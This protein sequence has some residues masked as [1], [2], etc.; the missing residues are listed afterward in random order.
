MSSCFSIRIQHF[1]LI[2]KLQ[3]NIFST[4]TNTS[5]N[6]VNMT[7]L[8]EIKLGYSAAATPRTTVKVDTNC[9]E[10]GNLTFTFTLNY[11]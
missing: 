2:S 5:Q 9:G 1:H 7:E 3:V 8:Q 6:L 10:L 4:D 11:S